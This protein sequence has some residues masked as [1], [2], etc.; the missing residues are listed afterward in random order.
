MAE[1]NINKR[2]FFGIDALL[3]IKINVVS[4]VMRGGLASHLTYETG[5]KPAIANISGGYISFKSLKEYTPGDVLEIIMTFPIPVKNTVC[6]YGEVV[7]VERTRNNHYQMVVR[8]INMSEKIREL[9]ITFVF[10]RE[11]TILTNTQINQEARFTSIPIS[12]FI[13]GTI[14][15]FEIFTKEHDGMKYLFGAG[16]PYDSIT[17]EFFEEK[18]IS[19]IFI[20]DEDLPLFYDYIS[21]FMV[22]Q[23]VFDRESLVSFKEYSF[24]KKH[25]HSIDRAILIPHTEINFSLFA[26]NDYIF[27]LAVKAGPEHPVTADEN[28][29]NLKGAI[30]IRKADIPIYRSYLNSLSVPGG[31]EGYEN[32]NTLVLKEHVKIIMHE[33]FT[34]PAN[35]ENMIEAIGIAERII[36]CLRRHA[37]SVYTLISLNNNDFYVYTHSTNVAVMSVAVGLAMKLKHDIIVGLCIGALLHDIGHSAINDEIVNKQGRL[38][39]D[40]YAVF[41]THVTEG[42][43]I[44]RRHDSVPPEALSAVLHHHE[45]LNGAG[46][47]SGLSG[48]RISLFGRITAIADA[49]DVLTPNR[50]YR[51]R[52]TPFAA[53]SIIKRDLAYYDPEILKVFIKILAKVK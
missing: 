26:M 5:L 12:R 30:L 39:K 25:Y 37:D 29:T 22:K 38:N 6:I 9:V 13:D 7:K 47:P 52:E 19:Q 35:N 32:L 28:I 16:L 1:Q 27:D 36:E 14:L 20:R 21:K 8:F 4:A 44:L 3:P 42:L 33:L 10:Q 49:Y 46:Y 43:K 40:E 2:D 50:P 34:D 24:S 48:N 23:K 17:R 15:P 51:K 45:K 53:L 31:K 11:R 18:E 41:K